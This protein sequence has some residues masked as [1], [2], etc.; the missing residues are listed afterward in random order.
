VAFVVKVEDIMKTS[1]LLLRRFAVASLTA[2]ACLAGSSLQLHA[3]GVS[4]IHTPDGGIQP[5]VAVD[6]K[7]TVH[8]I[9]LKGDPKAEN[10]FY[11][12]KE[13]GEEKFSAP[14]RVN[15]QPGSA[16]AMGTIRGAQIALGRN[17]RVHVAWN[18]NQTA[19]PKAP[20]GMPML[21]SRLNDAG[22]AFEAQRNLL[23][24]AAGLDGGGAVAA[25]ALGNVYV[26]WHG[27]PA[28]DGEANRAVFIAQS[29]DDGKTFE[30]ERRANSQSTGACGCCG[31]KVF[32]DRQG[33]V[34]ALYRAAF[35]TMNRD[36]TLLVSHDQGK[37]F[38]SA[39]IHSWKIGSCPMSSES[40]AANAGRVLAAWET[41]GKVFFAP[42]NLSGGKFNAPIFSPAPG[43]AKRRQPALAVN[44]KGEALLAWTEGTAWQKG[45]S[46]AWQVF[47]QNGQPRAEQGTKDGVPVWGLVAAYAQP[48]GKFVLIY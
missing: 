16:T 24:F 36:M 15:S 33:T 35:Q 41:D 13:A 21:Y 18:G 44:A 25:D 38:E 7:G 8:L 37:S 28:G 39:A 11:V 26:A 14:L 34:F 23:T 47:D 32:A 29:K 27:N 9:Y 3:A 48:D 43:A 31:M 45:G 46:V 19:E 10:I 40:F 30:A 5:Q 22:T 2:F 12:R 17:G 20:K 42:A 6:D 4:L 1:T